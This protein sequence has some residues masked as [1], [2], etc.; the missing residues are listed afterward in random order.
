MGWKL[1]I[2]CGRLH[3]KGDGW[4]NID[5]IES[6]NPDVVLDITKGFPKD[7]PWGKDNSV[8]FI[9]AQC[10]LGQIERNEDFLFVMN[11]CWR[12]LKPDGEMW[13]YL[14]HKDYP[15]AYVDPFNVRKFNELSWLAFDYR[16][17]QYINHNSYYG[18]KPWIVIDVHTN[19]K[20]FLSIRM[21]PKK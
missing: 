14:P 7:K 15:H 16:H 21:K 19:E 18:F 1:N 6:C 17:P 5:K 2:G 12:V 3:E 13:I 9:K 4:V 11:E 10:C 8:D 20:G